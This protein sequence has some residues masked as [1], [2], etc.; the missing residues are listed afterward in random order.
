MIS[1]QLDNLISIK[2]I[3]KVRKNMK[4][5]SL[6]NSLLKTQDNLVNNNIDKT[7]QVPYFE[8]NNLK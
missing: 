5:T 1:Y 4:K 8:V 2:F 3:P 6:E 7:L